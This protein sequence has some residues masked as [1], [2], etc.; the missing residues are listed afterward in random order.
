MAGGDLVEVMNH[1]DSWTTKWDILVDEDFEKARG[2]VREADHTHLAPPCKS[3]TKAR[4]SDKFGTTKVVR[5]QAQPEGWGDPLTVEGN[6]IVERV[7]VLLDEAQSARNT[8]SLEN[9]ED[10]FIWEQP[11]LERH[12][13]RMGKVGLD[14]CPYG[15]E[16]KK[17]T[18]ILTDASWMAMFVPGARRHD[19]TSICQVVWSERPWIISSIRQER[20]GKPL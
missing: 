12:M 1:Q 6:K 5:S 18:G 7:S 4:R 20:C 10:S 13:K 17:P 2:W 3:F 14:Q 9:P 19:H 15:A 16:T 8:T 11:T